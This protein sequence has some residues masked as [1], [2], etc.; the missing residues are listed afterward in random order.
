[1]ILREHPVIRFNFAG[2]N[3]RFRRHYSRPHFDVGCVHQ[4]SSETAELLVRS[5]GNRHA[6]EL[7]RTIV[8]KL[9]L[10]LLEGIFRLLNAGRDPHQN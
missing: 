1:M 5:T 9:S 6:R 8:I 7:K 4:V 10:R 2:D 3:A